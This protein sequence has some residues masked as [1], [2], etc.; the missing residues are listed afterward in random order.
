[1]GCFYSGC[2]CGIGGGLRRHS[3]QKAWSLRGVFSLESWYRGPRVKYH[4]YDECAYTLCSHKGICGWFM[5]L[6]F[7]C[8]TTPP[9]LRERVRHLVGKCQYF[10]SSSCPTIGDFEPRVS[11]N[12][13]CP[14]GVYRK[15][16][17]NS[18]PKGGAIGFSTLP[19]LL[20]RPTSR[21]GVV[22]HA[23]DSCIS[24]HLMYLG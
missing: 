9:S 15:I 14:V 10:A 19:N 16:V 20:S 11:I 1:V 5:Q 8:P 13:T 4:Q 24:H 12:D 3:N 6:S 22:G 17:I 7:F 23:I 18:C 2:L 21:M